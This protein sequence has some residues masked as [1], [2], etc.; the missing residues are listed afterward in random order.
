VI[1][2]LHLPSGLSAVQRRA[3]RLD[4][5]PCNGTALML[6]RSPESGLGHHIRTLN[7]APRALRLPL[8]KY[9]FADA[10]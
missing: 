3:D 8:H 2:A 4:A 10:K 5:V 9:P 1:L 6:N 7:R